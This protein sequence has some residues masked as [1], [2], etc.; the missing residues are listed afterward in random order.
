MCL[1]EQE[2][3]MLEIGSNYFECV[4]WAISSFSC[5]Y[6]EMNHLKQC[7]T[8]GRWKN[9][10]NKKEYVEWKN[11]S[12]DLLITESF[13]MTWIKWNGYACNL[14]R[15]FSHI[16]RIFVNFKCKNR[17]VT[18]K[19]SRTFKAAERLKHLNI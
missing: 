17:N 19:N 4:Y 16:K 1:R 3:Q 8:F 13:E 5:R 12:N 7:F 10:S 6:F 15:C 9:M 18:I 14:L 11:I 2:K